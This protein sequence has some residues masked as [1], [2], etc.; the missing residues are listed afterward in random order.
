MHRL[1]RSVL[2]STIAILSRP[3]IDM[4]GRRTPPTDRVEELQAKLEMALDEIYH[5]KHQ[6]DR[7]SSDYLRIKES[8][9]KLFFDIFS[10]MHKLPPDG[11]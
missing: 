1:K 3:L 8:W 4:L 5:L 11:K 9:K 10:V 2:P 7:L 6:L